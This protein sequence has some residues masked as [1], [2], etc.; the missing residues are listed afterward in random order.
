[1]SKIHIYELEAVY[2][3]VLRPDLGLLGDN[4]NIYFYSPNQQELV[5][6]IPELEKTISCVPPYTNTPYAQIKRSLKFNRCDRNITL[7]LTT[8]TLSRRTYN[9]K[10]REP[11]L[12]SNNNNSNKMMQRYMFLSNTTK[13]RKVCEVF[14]VKNDQIVEKMN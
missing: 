10:L 5:D 11:V 2:K 14:E 9:F 4:V 8:I 6:K 13:N 12:P 3:G 7:K 1:M